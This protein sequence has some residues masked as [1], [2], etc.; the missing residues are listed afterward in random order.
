[1]R[2]EG[3]PATGREL[4]LNCGSQFHNPFIAGDRK[5]LPGAERHCRWWR[6]VE[7]ECCLFFV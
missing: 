1:M 2:V 7:H 5:F 4:M 6:V 3:N